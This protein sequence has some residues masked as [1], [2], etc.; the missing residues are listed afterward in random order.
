MGHSASKLRQVEPDTLSS[1]AGVQ[2][3]ASKPVCPPLLV[4]PEGL[5]IVEGERASSRSEAAG[6]RGVSPLPPLAHSLGGE[7][8]LSIAYTF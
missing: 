6:G 2:V 7:H 3:I 4:L 8:M 1:S 5:G